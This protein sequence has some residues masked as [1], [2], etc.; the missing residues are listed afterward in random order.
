MDNYNRNKV[1]R[2]SS[3]VKCTIYEY[4]SP[5]CI[6]HTLTVTQLVND[7]P[8]VLYPCRPA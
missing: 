8:N 1:Q 3:R 6:L 4:N 5:E 2:Y 7:L